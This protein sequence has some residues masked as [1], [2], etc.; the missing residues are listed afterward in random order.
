LLF[1]TEKGIAATIESSVEQL[2][3]KDANDRSRSKQ[4]REFVEQRYLHERDSIYQWAERLESTIASERNDRLR[5]E[6]ELRQMTNMKVSALEAMSSQSKTTNEITGN[7][8]REKNRKCVDQNGGD[9]YQLQRKRGRAT[10]NPS[11]NRAQNGIKTEA[12]GQNIKWD[13]R[14][15]DD[16]VGRRVAC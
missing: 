10:D 1:S 2:W 6:K 5:F 14:W 13:H 8:I 4:V 11:K 3:E 9:D 12:G 16:K 7:D 15:Y